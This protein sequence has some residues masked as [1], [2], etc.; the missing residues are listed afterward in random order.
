[1]SHVGHHL[2]GIVPTLRP[3]PCLASRHDLKA[4]CQRSMTAP[5][6]AWVSMYT[7]APSLNDQRLLR[8]LVC[9]AMVDKVNALNNGTQA[10]VEPWRTR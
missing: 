1:M 4:L 5:R 2:K 9:V 8:D 6:F 10:E 3:E 7:K